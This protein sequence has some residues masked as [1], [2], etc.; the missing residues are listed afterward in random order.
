M[1]AK[2]WVRE[3]FDLQRLKG[4][5]FCATVPDLFWN[6]YYIHSFR[7]RARLLK[8]NALGVVGQRWCIMGPHG[9]A[10]LCLLVG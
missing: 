6:S 4:F 5:L 1:G 9:I 7:S 2:F 8:L 3:K 10:E